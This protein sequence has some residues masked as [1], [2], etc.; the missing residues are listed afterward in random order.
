MKAFN[1][2]FP[3]DNKINE[4]MT[5]ITI[6]TTKKITKYFPSRDLKNIKC[7]VNFNSKFFMVVGKNFCNENVCVYYI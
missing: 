3:V 1:V 5:Q 7:K 4:F 2:A 6:T